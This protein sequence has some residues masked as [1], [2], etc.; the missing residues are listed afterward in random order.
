MTMN[1]RRNNVRVIWSVQILATATLLVSVL[2]LRPHAT[3]ISCSLGVNPTADCGT[4]T[5]SSSVSSPTTNPRHNHTEPG[6]GSA[7]CD[8]W[9]SSPGTPASCS[10]SHTYANG[11]YT[12]TLSGSGDGETCSLTHPITV[13]CH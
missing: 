10:W 2:A 9:A 5:I 4:F 6:D 11:S 13:S 12:A 7:A 3:V 1:K 8:A